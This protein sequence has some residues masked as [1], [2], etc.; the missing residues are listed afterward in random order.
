MPKYIKY[1]VLLGA[2][3]LTLVLTNIP[4][5]TVLLAYHNQ[6]Q[7]KSRLFFKK[8]GRTLNSDEILAPAIQDLES[9]ASMN[10]LLSSKISTKFSTFSKPKRSLA[11][12]TSKPPNY[13]KRI[14]PQYPDTVILYNR[15]P[16]TGSTT[17][18]NIA[19]DMAKLNKFWCI[20]VNSTVIQCVQK[21][22]SD[23]LNLVVFGVK[24]SAK[25]SI[26]QN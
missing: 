25:K 26:F 13:E 18:A 10:N 14:H 1:L 23:Y 19:N 15:V 24:F 4:N 20:N 16:K 22:W 21:I 5:Q 6:T 9:T 11:T 8:S 2:G 7:N 17:F 12:L 3:V